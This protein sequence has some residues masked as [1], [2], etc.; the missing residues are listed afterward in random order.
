MAKRRRFLKLS[1][2]FVLVLIAL[3]FFIVSI[4]PRIPL[5]GKKTEH[6]VY[7]A[8]GFHTNL[9]HSYRIDTNDEAGFGKDIRIIRN[10]IETMDDY[11]ARGSNVAGVWDSDTIFT[12]QEIL[13]RYAPDIIDD[14]RRRVDEGRDEVIIMNY[15][16]GISSAMTEEEFVDTINRAITNPAG[17]GVLDLFGTFTPIV[18][19]Q[20]MMT[21]P[22]NFGLLNELGIEAVSLYYSAIVFD[23]F[24]VFSRPLSYEEAHN[25]LLLVNEEIGEEIVVIPT[26]NIGD[27]AE[28]V[29][30]TKWARDLHRLQLRGNIQNDVLIF[31]NFDADDSY[32]DGYTFPFYLSWLPN[33]GGLSQ[34]ID[35]IDALNYA[36]FTTL[37]DYLA[38]HEPVGEISFGQDTADGN[39]DGYD[40]WAQKTTSHEY[41][42]ALVED[43]RNHENVSLAYEIMGTEIPPEVSWLLSRSYELRLR[44]LS[45]TNF[46]MAAPFLAQKREEAAEEIIDEMLELSRLAW[47]KAQSELA[48]KIR[49]KPPPPPPTGEMEFIDSFMILT[50]EETEK[51]SPFALVP[52]DLDGTGIGYTMFYVMT[53]DGKLTAPLIV[54]EVRAGDGT[55][56]SLTLFLTEIQGSGPY[57]LF[58]APGAVFPTPSF[59]TTAGAGVLMNGDVR[60]EITND[61][62]ISGVY[63]DKEKR[64]EARS[65]LPMVV[66]RHDEVDRRISPTHLDIDVTRNGING[67]AQVRVSGIFDL[68]EIEG[69]QPGFVDYRFTLVDGLPYLFLDGRITYPRTPTPHLMGA[70]SPAP[71]KRK[72]DRRWYEVSPAELILSTRAT[73]ESPFKILKRNFLGVKSSYVLDYF[74]HSDENLSLASVNNHIT[75]EYMAVAGGGNGVAVAM[76]TG[77]TANLA[78]CPAKLLF[79]GEAD[80]FS[81][82]LNPFGAYWGPQYYHPTWGNRAGYD[83][84]IMSGQQYYSSAPTYNG[85]TG[86]FS[87]MIAFF[88]GSKV[89]EDLETD[90]IAFTRPPA[91]V[92]GGIIIPGRRHEKKE[93]PSAPRGVLAVFEEGKDYILWERA[94]GSPEHYLVYIGKQPGNY[95]EVIET[96]EAMIVLENLTAEERYFATVSAIF[97]DGEELRSAEEVTFVSGEESVEEGEMVL[98]ISLQLRVLLAG[99]LALI[100]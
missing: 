81:L 20:E 94:G 48:Q 76:D 83:V 31:I 30:I 12:L 55:V 84:A 92:T 14:M 3:F 41:W 86:D 43:R 93:L 10:I 6:K 53:P 59:D 82:R 65:F 71:L 58:G 99:I 25:P 27:L 75:G 54:D 42:T 74:K 29:S 60:I 8:L 100:N 16:N 50:G 47:E 73:K 85:Y 64:L 97:A 35:E 79:D 22:G 70:G 15:S 78:F 40:S 38:T 67:V 51:K 32:W 63:I 39:F 17:S 44:L 87:L 98:P 2:L 68:P 24:R 72:I 69:A 90:L 62:I 45:T 18:R 34:L 7:V 49:E 26:Y 5:I 57:F 1:S 19:P 95:D 33:T 21:T 91:V 88:D 77:V 56:V 4:V 13:P 9:Y 89:P 80:L 28:N 36:E 11:N 66:F 23:S 52:F 37:G 46:G 61:G 96:E